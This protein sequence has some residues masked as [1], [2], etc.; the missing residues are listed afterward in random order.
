MNTQL[1]CLFTTKQDLDKSIQFVL[2]NYTIIN[3]NIFVLENKT[4]D[5]EV[6]IT[7]NIQ[8]GTSAVESEWKTILVH[9]KK[10]SN[11]IYTIN[12]LNEVIK[13]KTGGQLDNTFKI[14]WSEFKNSI[15]TTSPTGYKKI[16][17]KVF[18][19]LKI[20]EQ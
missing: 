13:S 7:F 1:I 19:T 4:H 10:E 8:K 20:S 9:R 15:L 5:N 2:E 12:A 18:Q 3:P 6:F 17:T 16:P 14:E 11:T